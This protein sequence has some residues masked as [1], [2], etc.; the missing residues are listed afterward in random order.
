MPVNLREQTGHLGQTGRP[1]PLARR[2]LTRMLS[3]LV[4]RGLAGRPRP[5][6]RRGMTRRLRPIVRRELTGQ[7]GLVGQRELPRGGMRSNG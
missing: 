5:I 4:R 2:E 7:P 6:E 1:G 3:L